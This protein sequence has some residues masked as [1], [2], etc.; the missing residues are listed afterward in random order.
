M[1]DFTTALKT[2]MLLAD[3]SMGALLAKMGHG[4]PCPDELTVTKPEVI[5]SIHEAY[6]KAGADIV[7]ADCFGSTSPVL[8]HKGRAGKTGEF[9]EAAVKLARSQAGEERFVACDMGPTGEFMVPVGS[10]SF[11]EIYGW[12]YEQAVAGKKAGAD[13]AFIETQTDLAECRAACIAAKDAGLPVIASFSLDPRGR[14]LTG[15]ACETCAVVLEAAGADAVGINCSTGPDEMVNNILRMSKVTSLPL[16]VEPNA[17]LPVTAAD[18]SVSYPFTPEEMAESMKKLVAAGT[19]VIGGCCGTTPEH[20]ALMKPLLG[21]HPES[22]WDGVSYVASSRKIYALE[23]AL[24]QIEDIS[25]PED[26]YD[27]DEDTTMICVDA[28]EF[29]PEMVLETASAT[30]LPLCIKGSDPAKVSALLR[31]YPGKAAYKGSANETYGA[32]KI[33]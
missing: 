9:S 18:G 22:A 24:E 7:I 32:I 33:D 28:D 30:T 23:D 10:H 31:V 21:E 6:V 17:G 16:S 13:L 8:A 14:T 20:I 4:T 3:G 26:A 25:D 5:A 15:A 19:T 29:T 2:K 12:F 11:D 1:R 27:V